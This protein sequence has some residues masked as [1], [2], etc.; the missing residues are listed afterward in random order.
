MVVVAAFLARGG[1]TRT[2][3]GWSEMSQ[4]PAQKRSDGAIDDL[5]LTDSRRRAGA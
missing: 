4:K 3:I 2:R 1:G 5:R